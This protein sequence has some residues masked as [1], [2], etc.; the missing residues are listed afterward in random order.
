MEWGQMISN[1]IKK[2]I[3]I[4][5]PITAFLIVADQLVGIGHIYPDSKNYIA[6]IDFFRGIQT[7]DLIQ[8]FMYRIALPFIAFILSL[9]IDQSI[10]MLALNLIFTTAFLIIIFEICTEMGNGQFESMLA[11]TLIAVAHPTIY[12]G[13]TILVDSAWMFFTA[14]AILFMIRHKGL[15]IQFVLTVCIG[16]MFKESMMFVV[17]VFLFYSLFH[18][19]VIYDAIKNSVLIGILALSVYG[20]CILIMNP[21]YLFLWLPKFGSIV[22]LSDRLVNILVHSLILFVPYL[23]IGIMWRNKIDTKTRWLLISTIGGFFPLILM[24]AFGAAFAT[25]FIWPLY[26]GFA[27]VVARLN[28]ESIDFLKRSVLDRFIN[29]R[30]LYNTGEKIADNRTDA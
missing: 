21:N 29:R 10:A 17:I 16:V 23:I 30:V 20:L 14:L 6:I 24:S 3:Y 7:D 13:S 26:I 8:P 2:L 9:F 15:S 27:P 19:R 22:W 18:D 25:R 12:Y 5:I 1:A 4:I 11:T 28:R